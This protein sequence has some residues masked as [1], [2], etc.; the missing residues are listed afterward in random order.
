[1]FINQEKLGTNYVLDEYLE[2]LLIALV[3]ITFDHF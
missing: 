1:M 3:G 2:L